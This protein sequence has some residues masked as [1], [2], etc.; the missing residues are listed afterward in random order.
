VKVK[1][2]E[3]RTVKDG[4]GTTF[5]EGK[6]YDLEDASAVRWIRRGV[7]EQSTG[8]ASK[9]STVEETEEPSEGEE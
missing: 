6:V 2:L 5:E 4:T 7:A 8:R 9:P 3:T 1:F